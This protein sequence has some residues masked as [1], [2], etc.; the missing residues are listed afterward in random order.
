MG[1]KFQF[2]IPIALAMSCLAGTT[3]VWSAD[4]IVAK[5][6]PVRP[7]SVIPKEEPAI[8]P[9]T[10]VPASF[11]SMTEI[12]DSTVDE[13]E[14]IQER[15]RRRAARLY[16]NSLI[17]QHHRMKWEEHKLEHENCKD[18][19][20][21]IRGYGPVVWIRNGP[22]LRWHPPS[23]P[24]AKRV[25]GTQVRQWQG[26]TDIPRQPDI[27][28][29]RMFEIRDNQFPYP[30]AEAPA[31]GPYMQAPTQFQGIPNQIQP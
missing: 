17:A 11:S 21:Y 1:R 3:N 14:E 31:P 30:Y 23:I 26:V 12:Q 5:L 15:T 20:N 24:F 10:I 19:F 29:H 6:P 18:W 16:R 9:S 4:K 8:P 2:G 22:E 25:W 13:C 7:T 28:P 27:P